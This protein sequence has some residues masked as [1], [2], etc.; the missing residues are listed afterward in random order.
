MGSYYLVLSLHLLGATV[1]VGGH[2]VLVLGILPAALRERRAAIVTDFERR[3]EHIGMPALAV[4]IVTGLWL[5]ERLLGGLDEWFASTA[6]ARAVQVKL[7]LLAG[8]GALALHARLR[9]LPRLNDDTIG[10]LAW[11][12]RVVSVLAVLFVLVGATIRTGGYP[13]FG[14]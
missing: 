14:R 9:V 5:A 12:I 8:T 7:L 2:L 1:W 10:V 13:L 11:H 6:T 4:Q 3:Y